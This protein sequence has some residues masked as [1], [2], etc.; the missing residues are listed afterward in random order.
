M[1]SN[2][3]TFRASDFS[4][5]LVGFDETLR[6]F[7]KLVG[8]KAPA[9]PPYNIIKLSDNDYAID[10]AIAGFGEEDPID[11]SVDN[12]VL[13]VVGEKK[14]PTKDE[15]TEFIH[16]GISARGFRREF[17]LAHDVEVTE[18]SLKNGI[19]RIKLEKE[20]PES[21]VRKIPILK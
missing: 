18:A 14:F 8:S 21:T 9:Y 16:R 20:A 6:E 2:T 13:Y 3:L 19:L 17:R 12:H 10:L 11:V 7:E 5:F 1:T 4:P 15:D